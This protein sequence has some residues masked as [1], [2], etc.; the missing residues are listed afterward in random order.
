MGAIGALPTQSN[1]GIAGARLIA[2]GDLDRSILYHRMG[3]LG[4]GRMPPLASAVI[5][6][7]G[8][9]I[10]GRWIRSGM[11]MGSGDEDGDD[12]AD[13]FDNCR[14]HANPSQ[15]DSDADRIGN[16][17]DGDFNND[18]RVDFA[19]LAIF[20]AALGSRASDAR[21][22]ASVDMNGDGLVNSADLALFRGQFGNGGTEP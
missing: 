19:D 22:R 13:D 14:H 1:F 3:T 11:G 16:L 21:Y 6:E 12:Y 9:D 20:R 18:G 7:A 15:L 17:C 4:S 2:P 8:M 10:I 5:D